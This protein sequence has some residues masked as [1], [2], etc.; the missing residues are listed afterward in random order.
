MYY[1]FFSL[2]HA[3]ACWINLL[4][5]KF[6]MLSWRRIH[7]QTMSEENTSISPYSSM[8]EVKKNDTRRT[9]VKVHSSASGNQAPKSF[10]GW[11][12]GLWIFVLKRRQQGVKDLGS[13]HDSKPW[14]LHHLQRAANQ[15]LM[16]KKE[17][18]AGQCSKKGNL[19]LWKV[20]VT[21]KGP[22]S[23][24]RAVLRR[25]MKHNCAVLS[26]LA[27]K[28]S[29]LVSFKHKVPPKNSFNCVHSDKQLY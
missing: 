27:K 22:H 7:T 17:G 18:L 29:T 9:K 5:L 26:L 8:K 1:W 2:H 21:E 4:K 6:K 24:G 23:A 12:Q 28:A 14:E 10:G 13:W 11:D 3:E 16:R 25:H 20:T 15:L 19:L